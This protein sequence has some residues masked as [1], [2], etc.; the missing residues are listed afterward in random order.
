MTLPYSIIQGKS[1]DTQKYNQG[2][3]QKPSTRVHHKT[4]KHQS[5]STKDLIV[6]S[7]IDQLVCRSDRASLNNANLL[8]RITVLSKCEFLAEV[9]SQKAL[10]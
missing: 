2:M 8:L 9:N 6:R 4:V 1:D 3:I 7:T 10:R 5:T